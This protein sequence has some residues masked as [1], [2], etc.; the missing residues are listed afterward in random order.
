MSL[1]TDYNDLLQRRDVIC[2]SLANLGDLRPGSLKSRYRQCG[3]PNCHC[4]QPGDP[5][6]GPSWFLSRLVKGKMHS[7]AIPAEALARTRAQL[8]ECQRLRALTAELIEVSDRLCQAQLAA[9]LP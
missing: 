7:R 9:G 4:A 6:H 5:G 2:R 8:A 1:T 3:K